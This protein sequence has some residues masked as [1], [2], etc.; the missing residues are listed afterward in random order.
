[1][2]KI[3][4]AITVQQALSQSDA[5]F[6][7]YPQWN[8]PKTGTESRCDKEE[9]PMRPEANCDDIYG[10]F[11]GD[12]CTVYCANDRML[13]ETYECV[14]ES[15]KLLTEEVDCDKK[16]E[17]ETESAAVAITGA[18]VFVLSSIAIF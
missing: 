6:C 8:L 7:S 13:T 1:M 5:G 4:F 15:W 11:P 12:K 9:C 2:I 10:V 3:C 18:L 14:D 17:T 16:E